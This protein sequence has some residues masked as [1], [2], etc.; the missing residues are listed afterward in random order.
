MVNLAR[1]LR[2]QLIVDLSQGRDRKLVAAA[3]SLSAALGRELAADGVADILAQG[4]VCTHAVLASQ[5]I[6]AGEVVP[7]V[8]PGLLPWEG[9]V[10][11]KVLSTEYS[12]LSM[13]FATHSAAHLYDE[14]LHGFDQ[15][16]RK[17]GGVF[18]T[19]QPIADYIV[20]EVDETLRSE[21]GITAGLA[22]DS[23]IRNPHSAIPC[24]LDPAAGTGVFLLAVIEHI[25]RTL[26][27]GW[28]QEGARG[29]EIDRRWNDYVPSL[30]P[31]L[32]GIE[33]LPVPALLAKLN[34]VIKLA[35]T[36]YRFA[37]P[38]K[39][40]VIL[41]D[42]LCPSTQSAIR[43]PQSAIPVIIGNPPFSSLSTNSNEW[44]ARLVR[45]DEEVRGYIRANGQQL[46]ERKTWLHDDYVKFIRLAQWRVEQAGCGIVGL[47]TNHGYL[48]N[49]TFRLMRQE[50][51]RVFPR[52]RVVDLHG[53]RK[54]GEIAP[55][56]GRDENVFGLDQ[57]V[58]IGIFCRPSAPSRSVIE[59]RIEYAE[60]WGSRENKLQALSHGDA[61]T[62]SLA[63]RVSV[64][65]PRPPQWRFVPSDWASHPE[66]ETA[67]PLAEAMPIHS[68]APITARDH[69]VVAMSQA[70]LERRIEEFRDL[71]I[72]DDEIR[73]RYFMRTRSARYQVGDS[74]GWQLAG[75]R[76]IVA[77]DSDWRRH[78]VRCLYRPFDW[79]YV[80]WHP[81]MIDWPRNDVT[82]HLVGEVSSK[83]NVQSS[84]SITG[85]S[86][87]NLELG[88]LNYCLI[89][90]RQQLPMQPCTFFWIADGLA[91]DGVIR[92]DNRGSESLFPLYVRD[93]GEDGGSGWR[94]NFSAKFVESCCQRVRMDWLPLGRGDLE[95]RLGPEDLLAYVY[96]LFHAPSYRERYAEA[97]RSD[98]PRVPAPR[99]AALFKAMCL[100]GRE[101]IGVH[102]LK[103]SPDRM[104]A[105]YS[106]LS[107][108]YSAPD[109]ISQF[110][111]GGYC[112]V[113]KWLQ[114]AGRSTA[115]PQFGL[116]VSAIRRTIELMN[117]IDKAILRHGGVE[118]AF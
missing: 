34:M 55:G 103:H 111:V 53:N 7:W 16:Q 25:H 115:D 5:P 83:F 68:T 3:E 27:E 65:T 95:G 40:N 59:G 23:A 47:I 114:P 78:I 18:F 14:F 51:L 61:S 107:T 13:G 9:W 6:L 109:D 35:Q 50:L 82:R 85:N 113:R 15:Q 84:R 32:W 110:C 60:L 42:A 77:A 67:W 19:P 62:P 76:R 112:V 101:M 75:A 74:R 106:V 73:R 44:I 96:A 117:E 92:S 69:F 58:A 102:L 91:L 29:D 56:G 11:N 30:L 72:S 97:L 87:L 48:D 98:F 26:A 49:A 88:T 116:I 33:L 90:R 45:G 66:Y 28:R 63:R 37:E 64:F 81:A 70:E 12:V 46:A 86:T 22:A 38:V 10:I 39:I 2:E 31:R 71:S 24:I 41:G 52:A 54:K 36:G 57:G 89:A 80:F 118:R 1:S 94:G 43:N 93:G 20:A 108:K 100:L 104:A 8:R 17:R 21:C 4:I 99:N 79:R 105:A